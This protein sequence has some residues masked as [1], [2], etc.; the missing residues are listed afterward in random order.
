[1]TSHLRSRRPPHLLN[2]LLHPLRIRKINQG[3][4]LPTLPHLLI[5][6]AHLDDLIRNLPEGLLWIVWW[7]FLPEIG[8]MKEMLRRSL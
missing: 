6:L 1:M 4:P 7:R 3:I 2:N 8:R 5:G